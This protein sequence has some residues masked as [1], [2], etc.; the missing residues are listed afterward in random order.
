MELITRLIEQ[1]KKG[2]AVDIS[3][4]ASSGQEIV[5]AL[6]N[7]G[8]TSKAILMEQA[9]RGLPKQSSATTGFDSRSDKEINQASLVHS[10]QSLEGL[11][12]TLEVDDNLEF[13]LSAHNA[14]CRLGQSSNSNGVI[15]EMLQE[16]Q[17][18]VE[19]S[20]GNFLNDID[21]FLKVLH[22]VSYSTEAVRLK[23]LALELI[24]SASAVSNT[25]SRH[26]RPNERESLSLNTISTSWDKNLQA[27]LESLEAKI[28]EISL[29]LLNCTY[30]VC[31]CPYKLGMLTP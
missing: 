13:L 2:I 20:M 19:P 30:H 7:S 5:A 9:L 6:H 28:P 21:S 3:P 18:G 26:G 14:L 4:L 15:S 22:V 29:A 31:L 8:L 23:N 17:K 10:I 12:A 27:V 16:A 25:I 24:A 11:I 1:T